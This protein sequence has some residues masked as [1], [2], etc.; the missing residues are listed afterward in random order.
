MTEKFSVTSAE[1]FEERQEF[2]E[3][4]LQNS[5]LFTEQKTD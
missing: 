4:F 3:P 1:Q 5:L 2:M